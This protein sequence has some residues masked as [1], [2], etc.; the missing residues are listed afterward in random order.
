MT[1]SEPAPATDRDLL[2][3]YAHRRDGAAF[4]LLVGRYG[5]FVYGV[6]R[7]VLGD[8]PD[9]DDA[10][11]AA[12]LVLARKACRV[13]RPDQLGGWLHTV[14]VRCARRARAAREA[15]RDRERPMPDVPAR[16]TDPDWADVRPVLDE[17][18]E[19][20]PAKLRSALVLCE[21]RGLDRSA[22]AVALGV[23]EGTLS[24]RLARGKDALRRR[25]VR[26]GVTLTAL[27]VG[28]ALADAARAAVP[29]GHVATAATVGGAG[30]GAAASLAKAEVSA[31]F[32]TKAVKVGLAAAV[33]VAAGG[34]VVVG[35]RPTAVAEDRQARPDQELIRGA[36]VVT[37]A[38]KNGQDA[39]DREQIGQRYGFGN[40]MMRFGLIGAKWTLDPSKEPK[41]IDLVVTVAPDGEK[42]KVIRGLYK[43]DGD[44][45][46]LHLS[47]PGG[48]RPAGFEN[49]AGENS[50]LLS[51]ERARK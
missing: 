43:L 18:I 25:L 45:L 26:R 33:L 37:A 10:F 51:L 8:G 48:E 4:A 41:K 40:E 22:A 9:A 21:L 38:M 29:P 28:M 15:R 50:T 24:S 36:W 16:F 27:G 6:C 17:E 39:P 2:R 12:F 1:E 32:W 19:A 47:Q 5:S 7:R 20:L 31:M 35:L 11:Q 34:G 13:G 44:K 14:A 23:P 30:S 42:G 49:R 3:E 46:T